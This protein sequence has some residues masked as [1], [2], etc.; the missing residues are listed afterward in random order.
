MPD[1]T[2]HYYAGKKKKKK[3]PPTNQ[4]INLR[5]KWSFYYFKMEEREQDL[6]G[7]INILIH[8]QLL[9]EELPCTKLSQAK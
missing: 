9:T 8:V 1:N 4:R 2:S 7:N 5:P 3:K 6:N